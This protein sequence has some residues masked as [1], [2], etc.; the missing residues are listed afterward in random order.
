MK[1]LWLGSVA[2]AAALL[3]AC[4]SGEST[5]AGGGFETSDVTVGVYTREN[6]PAIGARVWL[7]L[8][9]GDSLPAKALDST[10]VDSTGKAAL[11]APSGLTKYGFEAVW[12]ER[13]EAKKAIQMGLVYDTGSHHITQMVLSP[14]A[15]LQPAKVAR[16]SS[17]EP[18]ADGTPI[19]VEGSHFVYSSSDTAAILLVPCGSRNINVGQPGKPFWSS[20][21]FVDSGGVFV[22]QGQQ[23]GAGC[24]DDFG[25]LQPGQGSQP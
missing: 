1:G 12:K 13:G 16:I 15:N 9:Q 22:P 14:A 17:G 5:V 25:A 6:V 23:Q 19:F 3:Q 2:L 7:L 20:Q 11:K 10:V 21:G 8:S 24:A 4:A 18:V